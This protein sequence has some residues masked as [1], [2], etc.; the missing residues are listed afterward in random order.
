MGSSAEY[1]KA[2]R[3][4]NREKYLARKKSYRLRNSVSLGRKN[5]KAKLRLKYGITVELFD[6]M[7]GVQGNRCAICDGP[8]ESR[9]LVVNHCHRTGRVVALLCHNCNSAIGFLEEDPCIALRAYNY[10]LENK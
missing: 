10:I 2:Y 8:P 9:G 5:R 6:S 1:T 4:K 3:V 7:K